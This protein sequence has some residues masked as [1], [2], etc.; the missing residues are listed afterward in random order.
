MIAKIEL[1]NITFTVDLNNGIDISIP[2]DSNGPRAWYKDNIIIKPVINNYFTGKVSLGGA[3]NFND[4]SFNPHAHG[5][6]TECVG[7]ISKDF[8][9]INKTLRQFHF[10]VQVITVEPVKL[11]NDFVIIASQLEQ[12][13]K[14]YKGIFPK[15]LAIRTLPNNTTKQSFNYSNT[16][17]T[18]MDA[19]CNV[20]LEKTGIEHLLIDLPS[21]DKEI[22]GG[23]LAMHHAFW[24]YPK[25]ANNLKTITEFIH[26]PSNIPDG[27]Y[28]LNL[29]IAPFENDATPSKPVIYKIL[30]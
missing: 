30:D 16:N 6:H 19:A 24:N 13:L 12:T 28:L 25:Q 1:K 21:V 15:A 14:D 10:M 26:I 8:V 27:F 7:H 5:T 23:E 29:Q 22:D 20:V 9:S 11:Q 18:Y 2:L 3:V 17:P 4:I